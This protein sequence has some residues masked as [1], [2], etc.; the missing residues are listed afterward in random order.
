MRWNNN[1]ASGPADRR[2][3]IHPYGS[4]LSILDFFQSVLSIEG[5]P[6]SSQSSLSASGGPN[7]IPTDRTGRQ[8]KE[9]LLKN[10]LLII[11]GS[12]CCA[13]CFSLFFNYYHSIIS[14]RFMSAVLVFKN[15]FED[16]FNKTFSFSFKVNC[17]VED[18]GLFLYVLNAN[19]H[20][21]SFS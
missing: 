21:T 17:F 8:N 9:I 15:V 3:G 6:K 1:K 12:R 20:K 18:L 4:F 13:W 10:E 7:T 19:N 2:W 11:H 5:R 16:L 14:F